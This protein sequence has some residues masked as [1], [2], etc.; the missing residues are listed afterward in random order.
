MRGRTRDDVDERSGKDHAGGECTREEEDGLVPAAE[1]EG[2]T[3]PEAAHAMEREV[4]V[5]G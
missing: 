1:D 2:E 3:E 4:E 5:Q